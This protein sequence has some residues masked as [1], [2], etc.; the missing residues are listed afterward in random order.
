MPHALKLMPTGSDNQRGNLPSTGTVIQSGE[1][2]CQCWKGIDQIIQVLYFGYGFKTPQRQTYSL[3]YDRRLPDSCI[4]NSVKP[5][6]LRQSF[7][8][9]VDATQNTGVLPKR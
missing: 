6:F 9:L 8:L 1:I 2:V 7:R 5:K 3:A 4:E